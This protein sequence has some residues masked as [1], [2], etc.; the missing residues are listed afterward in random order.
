M[1]GEKFE[2]GLEIRRKVLGDEHV[3]KSMASADDF[4]LP[5]QQLTTEYCWG[6][7]WSREGLSLKTRSMLNLAMLC[8][9]NRPRELRLHIGGALRNG[10]TREEIR[11]IFLQTAIYAGIPAASTAFQVAREYFAEQ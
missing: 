4:S 3:D 2:R 1:T 5:Y 9:L 10:V 7:I 6:E 8:V 11:E